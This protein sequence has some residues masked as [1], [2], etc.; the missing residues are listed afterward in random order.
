MISTSNTVLAFHTA[1]MFQQIELSI[2]LRPATDVFKEEL[3]GVLIGWLADMGQC[4]IGGDRD[5]FTRILAKALYE[6]RQQ[7]GDVGPGTPLAPELKE[8]EWNAIGTQAK[9]IDWIMRLDI[10]MWKRTKFEWRQIYACLYG[11]SWETQRELGE[12]PP[13]LSCSVAD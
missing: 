2:T 8:L 5:L 10:K 1:S 7:R 13:Y 3:A 4:T 12:R 11:L 9:R 6:P